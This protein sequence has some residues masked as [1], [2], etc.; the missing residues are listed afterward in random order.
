VPIEGYPNKKRVK[1]TVIEEV[2]KGIR[3]ILAERGCLPI[4]K[5]FLFLL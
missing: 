5:L 3:M 2:P 4:G 1:K